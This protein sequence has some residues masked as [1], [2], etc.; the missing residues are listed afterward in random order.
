MTSQEG[1]SGRLVEQTLVPVVVL[2]TL[3]LF[4]G[5]LPVTGAVLWALVVP[6]VVLLAL[7]AVVASRASRTDRLAAAAVEVDPR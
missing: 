5:F 1:G 3:A 4:V 6:S 7:G 2:S